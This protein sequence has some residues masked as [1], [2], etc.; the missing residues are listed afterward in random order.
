[1]PRPCRLQHSAN[2]FLREC[3]GLGLQTLFS[4]CAITCDVG[5]RC[6]HMDVRLRS[7]LAD[8]VCASLQ[9]GLA[10][11]LLRAENGGRAS[12]SF[13]SYSVVRASAAAMSAFDFSIAPS[14]RPWRS[15]RTRLNG[16]CTIPV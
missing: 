11:S 1:M 2:N 4:A 9:S 10:F 15:L 6:L 16:L 3:G 12:R 8:G 14:V 7:R 5:F 13:C